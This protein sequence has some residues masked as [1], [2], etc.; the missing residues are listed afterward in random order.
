MKLLVKSLLRSLFPAV[1]VILAGCSSTG[2]E[3][4]EPAPDLSEEWTMGL[5]LRLGDTAAS[6][7]RAPSDG[8]YDPGAGYENYIDMT[9]SDPDMRVYLFTADTNTLISELSAPKVEFYSATESSKTYFLYFEINDDF[10][11]RY[12]GDGKKFKMV[13]LANWRHKYPETVAGT[14][15]I[16]ELVK[17]TEAIMDYPYTPESP[18][19]A[20]LTAADAIPLFGVS[21]YSDIEPGDPK[22]MTLLPQTL[23]L[24]R[25]Y[26]KVELF[27]A[28]YTA[29]FAGGKLDED[30]YKKLNDIKSVT[31]T[32]YSTKL[33]KA[34]EGVVHQDD[35]VKGNYEQD[36]GP[37]PTLV[38]DDPGALNLPLL[39]S[40]D[41]HFI[42]YIPE[43]K[44][45]D[46]KSDEQA[47]LMVR[48]AD[49]M[50]YDL[51]FKDYANPD[52]TTGEC[53]CF[54]IRRNYWY[55]FSLRRGDD[56]PFTMEV[57]VVPYGEVI[58]EP[59]FGIDIED[60]NP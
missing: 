13:M 49:G 59:D 5:Y 20:S 45:M 48:Y 40:D 25:A 3:T 44:N 60:G 9:G 55:R 36:Y 57:D 12:T 8:T 22:V 37:A 52:A 35:Y 11:S 4:D 29:D 26:A 39:R 38:A 14:T 56:S 30:T 1:G 50:V 23:H 51:E 24:L 41:G 16:D 19:P 34:P 31:L 54:D 28:D 15:T 6:G 32:R 33:R 18:I 17:S 27:A 2:A 21:E 43:F 47:R 46:K 7:S 10:K 58:L 42:T 53:A